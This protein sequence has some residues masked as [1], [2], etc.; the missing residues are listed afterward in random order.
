[1]SIWM[2]KAVQKFINLVNKVYCESPQKH[3]RIILLKSTGTWITSWLERNVKT[4]G[5]AV[6]HQTLSPN[7]AISYIV[8]SLYRQHF[9]HGRKKNIAAF[10]SADPDS[11]NTTTAL[12]PVTPST[13][14]HQV[15]PATTAFTPNASIQPTVGNV[16]TPFQQAPASQ[17][18]YRNYHMMPSIGTYKSLNTT[19]N[20][21]IE[22]LPSI[23]LY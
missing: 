12:N 18:Q 17:L 11:P 5:H 3:K 16:V 2:L 9:K 4:P 6:V 21:L 7:I 13:T 19:W 20:P 10:A 8:Y 23:G 15:P 14:F 1:M 22:E